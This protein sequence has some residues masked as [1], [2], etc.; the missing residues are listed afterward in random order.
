MTTSGAPDPAARP[1]TLLESIDHTRSSLLDA[2]RT[3]IIAYAGVWVVTFLITGAALLAAATEDDVPWSWSLTAPGQAVAMS[4]HGT[5]DYTTTVDFDDEFDEE[6]GEDLDEGFGED[7]DFVEYGVPDEGFPDES[8]PSDAIPDEDGC[9]DE[10]EELS[11]EESAELLSEETDY[12]MI[13][14]EITSSA[15]FTT[16][17]LTVLGLMIGALWVASRRA[18]RRRPT[19]SR[20][21]VLAAAT[22][23]GVTFAVLTWAVAFAARMHIEDSF[24]HAGTLSILFYASVLG[25]VVALLARRPVARRRVVSRLPSELTAAVR[26]VAVYLAVF[27]TLLVPAAAIYA[28]AH[29]EAEAILTFPLAILNIA[30]YAITF[31]QLAGIELPGLPFADD[32]GATFIW[33]F[34]DDVDNILFVL[35]PLT[36]AA[37]ALAV[38]V[39]ARR[40]SGRPRTS[41]EAFWLVATFAGAGALLTAL[42]AVTTSTSTFGSGLGEDG[43]GIFSLSV[44][45]VP[46][47]FLAM[48]GWGVVTEVAV[49]TV[50]RPLAA[51]VPDK[52]LDRLTGS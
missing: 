3:G 39:L 48:A 14:G 2:V 22:V 36:I 15:R 9:C 25:T 29:G 42:S 45:P 18:E 35:I 34:S 44:T 37:L 27:A 20:R 6:F 33:L 43:G 41:V 8:S 47:L 11:D 26:G 7:E 12:P 40:S 10:G 32:S 50:G 13:G 17:S 30:V 19:S 49:R 38:A 4:S 23:T 16:I 52:I 1:A 31:G 46:W 5:F 21:A 51:L 24:G 28:I